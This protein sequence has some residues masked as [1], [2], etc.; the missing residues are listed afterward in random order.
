[1]EAAARARDLSM[2][3]VEAREALRVCPAGAG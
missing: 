3:P 2:A 1:M